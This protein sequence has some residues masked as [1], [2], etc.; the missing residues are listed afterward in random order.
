MVRRSVIAG[1]VGFFGFGAA[2]AAAPQ[3]VSPPVPTWKPSFEQPRH[4]IIDRLN[5]YANGKRDFV[6]FKHGTCVVLDDGVSDE[7]ARVFAH[8]VLSEILGQHPDMF[9]TPMDDGNMMVSYNHPAVNIVLKDVAE[10]HWAEVERRHLDGLTPSE[11]LITPLGP[12]KFD[13]TG[14][15]ALLGRAYMFMDAQQPEVSGIER[16]L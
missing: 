14:K 12:N 2:K 11:V 16:H 13:T 5:Y 4:R 3:V 7:M 9:P 8:N 6:V 1:L 10:A 15:L